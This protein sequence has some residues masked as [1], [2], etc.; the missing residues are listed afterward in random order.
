MLDLRAVRSNPE[1]FRAGLRRKHA[2]PKLIDELL[3]ADEAWRAGLAEVER[4]KA[5]RNKASEAIARK[6]K[7][8]ENAD[9]DIAEMRTVSEQIKSLDEEVRVREQQVNELL[10]AIP[11][12]PHESVP[13]GAGE[14]DNVPLRFHGQVPEFDFEPKPHWDIA[15]DLGIVDFERAAKVT[16]SR[17]VIYKGLGAKLERALASF[18]LDWHTEKNGY[19]E[20]FPSFIANEDSFVGTGQLPKFAEDMFKLEGLPYYLIPTAEV[21]L[22]NYYREEILDASM[23][24]V[25]FAGYSA[26]FRSEAGSAGKDTRGLIRLH[27]FQK[28]E[29]VNLVK[30]EESYEALENLLRDCASILEALELPYRVLDICA[31]DLGA[32]ETKKYDLE[33]W[34]PAQRT[35]RE[36]SSVSNFED[37]QSRRAGLRFRR[38]EGA[39]PEFVHTLN[40]SGLAIGRTVAAI[41]ENGQQPDGT[42]KLP[43]ALV[44]YMGVEVLTAP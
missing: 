7:Q 24:P 17:F 9:A 23:L 28:V 1:R 41:L 8:G 12:P 22:T 37:F 44:P 33:V 42:V 11:I 35:Y 43:K 26:C 10:L 32:K 36:I 40:G 25:K 14:E 13:D 20:M 27:Q 31:G 29:L 3:G 4:L 21:P 38:E 19:T 39:K 16:G 30:P 6:K 18:M 2:D 5:V 15:Q 34:L